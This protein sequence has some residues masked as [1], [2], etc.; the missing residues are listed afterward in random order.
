MKTSFMASS[1]LVFCLLNF[2]VYAAD[3]YGPMVDPLLGEAE[4]LLQET[5]SDWI[6]RC[7]QGDANAC[8]ALFSYHCQQGNM[9]ACNQLESLQRRGKIPGT[10][11]TPQRIDPTLC[12]RWEATYRDCVRMRERMSSAARAGM[13]CEQWGQLLQRCY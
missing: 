8:G 4:R 13:N 1:I 11:R 12:R 6:T 3:P 2:P 7:R 10:A 9:N 5:E